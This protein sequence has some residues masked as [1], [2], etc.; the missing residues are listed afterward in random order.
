MEVTTVTDTVVNFQ[1]REAGPVEIDCGDTASNLS[2]TDVTGG[3][4]GEYFT[5]PSTTSDMNF[6]LAASRDDAHEGVFVAFTDD[7]TGE[8]TIE[9]V[10]DRGEILNLLYGGVWSDRLQSVDDIDDL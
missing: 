9:R 6:R 10:V 3:G 5:V 8:H 7:G 1:A 2:N 4:G